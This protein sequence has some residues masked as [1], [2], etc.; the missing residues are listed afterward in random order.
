MKI[1][2][3][4]LPFYNL[5]EMPTYFE[6]GPAYIASFLNQAGATVSIINCAS[7]KLK[8]ETLMQTLSRPV[9]R[10]RFL[11]S[12]TAQKVSLFEEVMSNP[13][14]PL[15]ETITG[16][17]A[18]EKPDAI[19]LTLFT[20]RMTGAKIIC[21]HIKANL[22]NIP[23]IL[24][25]MHPSSLPI[26]TLNEIPEADYIVVGEGEE[27]TKELIQYLD[28]PTPQGL[29]L[30]KGIAYRD[31]LKGPII[32]ER[33]ELIHDLDSLPFPKRGK[34][35][36]YMIITGR[37]CPYY[38]KFCASHVLWTRHVRYRSIDNVIE[39]INELKTHFGAKRIRIV[40]DT[41]TL[42]KKRV[43]EFSRK[44][45]EAKLNDI[46]Y[47]IGS[48]VDT[49]DGEKIAALQACGV[50]EITFGIESGSP[51]ILQR[52]AKGITPEQV[53]QVIA[54][55][56]SRNLTTYTYYMIGHPGETKQDIDQS[57][58]LL[59]QSKPTYAAINMVTIYP[60]T[61]YDDMAASRNCSSL[62]WMST[63]RDSTN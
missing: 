13:R 17:I 3:A 52:I 8:P 20:D 42:S 62:P 40:D 53:K 63:T 51:R 32:N 21:K 11:L 56:N 37:S 6:L 12:T 50:K 7:M 28:N 43:I 33:R 39:E 18:K 19:G 31:D 15:W 23:I 35:A 26:E 5:L 29:Q 58:Q 9:S 22:G 61:G 14:H 59:R 54:L 34:G 10:L 48:R 45:R 60:T 2:L 36:E 57:K 38:C 41:F 55:S 24:G 16:E 27:T 44:I 30:I 49:I 47:S 46:D 4:L 1:V 25:G